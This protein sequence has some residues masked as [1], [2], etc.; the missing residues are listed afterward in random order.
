MPRI[1]R[2]RLL[3]LK[4]KKRLIQPIEM[5]WEEV[6]RKAY[7]GYRGWPFWASA[8]FIVGTALI[9]GFSQLL[10]P[11]QFLV[12][13]LGQAPEAAESLESYMRMRGSVSLTLASLWVVSFLRRM[14]IA[15]Y[16]V[17]IATLFVGTNFAMDLMRIAVAEDFLAAMGTTFF[18]VVRPVL[19]LS[20]VTSL[21]SFMN[22]IPYERG[23]APS[24][25][26]LWRY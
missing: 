20:L 13:A 22:T 17:L 26:E 2:S 12:Y 16:V 19:L 4:N 24:N 6:A 23:R 14:A 9:C 1:R 15:R 10:F 21:M 18:L 3:L 7:F 8:I 11:K 5:E 25:D